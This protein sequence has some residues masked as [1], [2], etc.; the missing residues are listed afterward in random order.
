MLMF[1]EHLIRNILEAKKHLEN[2]KQKELIIPERLLQEPNENEIKKIYNPKPLR[3]IARGNIKLDDE[4]LNKE[5]A[6]KMI[7]PYY[8]TDSNL[9]I[10]FK[11]NLDSHHFSHA[12]SKL[13]IT[14]NFSEFSI[15]TRYFNE[16]LTELSNIYARLIN[17][18]VSR[19]QTVCSARFDKQEEDNQVLDE[20]EMFINLN[21]NHII[22]ESDLD[23]ID[24]KFPLENHIQQQEM[25]DSG[26]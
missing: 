9:K 20:T 22:T 5:L 7:N 18:Y 19:Y 6:K 4:Q 16:I 8:F 11:T 21:S 17:Q 25:K 10:G 12:N 3:Q 24:N 26:W 1:I 13:T 14:T 2:E 23:E 15:Q